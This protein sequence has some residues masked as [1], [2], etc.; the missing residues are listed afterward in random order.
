[1]F[2]KVKKVLIR[3]SII[4]LEHF[5]EKC[6]VGYELQNLIIFNNHLKCKKCLTR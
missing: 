3:K 6:V 2:N 4:H 1:M 5:K